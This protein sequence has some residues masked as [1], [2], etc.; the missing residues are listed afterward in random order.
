[1][2]DM[3]DTAFMLLTSIDHLLMSSG[4]FQGK[5]EKYACN[6]KCTYC[7]STF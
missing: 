5:R 4:I 7:I 3:V 6:L 2:F 1:M